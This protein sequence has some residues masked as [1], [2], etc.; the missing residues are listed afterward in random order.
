MRV[1]YNTRVFGSI[2]PI[3]IYTSDRETPTPPHLTCLVQTKYVKIVYTDYIYSFERAH[4]T[5]NR[6]ALQGY[7]KQLRLMSWR[8]ESM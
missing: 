6:H 8:C 3:S 4:S 7:K 2:F 1:Y 5:E